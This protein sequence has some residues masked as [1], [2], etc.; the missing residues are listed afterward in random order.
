MLVL[1]ADFRVVILTTRSRQ[2]HGLSNIVGIEGKNVRRWRCPTFWLMLQRLQL[3]PRYSW[4][5][6]DSIT[7]LCFTI[8][9]KTQLWLMLPLL[10]LCGLYI[11]PRLLVW[12]FPLIVSVPLMRWN[13]VTSIGMWCIAW[14]RLRTPSLWKHAV[15][16]LMKSRTP[17]RVKVTVTSLTYCRL[18]VVVANVVTLYMMRSIHVAMANDAVKLFLLYGECQSIPWMSPVSMLWCSPWQ[19]AGIKHV[20]FLPGEWF[21]HG[22]ANL[23]MGGSFQWYGMGHHPGWWCY[24]GLSWRVTGLQM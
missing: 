16:K 24:L 2:E 3:V 19:H 1:L 17:H 11:C 12:A 13:W 20:A 10:I 4:H 14:M 22:G 6:R 5:C 15:A 8:P 21:H 9:I 18:S 23:L 7:A